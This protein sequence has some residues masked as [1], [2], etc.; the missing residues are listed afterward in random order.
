MRRLILA[1]VCSACLALAL[2]VLAAQPAAPAVAQRSSAFVATDV[3]RASGRVRIDLASLP[4]QFL[5][6]AT[7]E[8]A[9]GS[10]D[11]GLDRA[12][13]VDPVL[14]EFR[15]AGKRALLVQKNMR[16]VARSNDPDESAATRDAFA[17]SVLWAGDVATDASGRA[18]ID[19]DGLLTSDL[20][21][22]VERLDGTKQGKYAL[23]AERS[24]VLADDTR[25]FPDN[26]EFAAL[27]TFAGDGQG[28]FARQA[29]ADAKRIT[30]K[31]RV[32]FVRLPDA[33]YRPRAYHPGSG[34]YSLAFFDFAR[35]IDRNLE[36]R[37]Q[38]RF[39]LEKI[40]P[41]AA[42]S[43]V[44]K[45]IV[46]YL[47]R[48][49]PEPI[50][51]A[52]LEG[53]NWWKAAFESAGFIDAFRAEIAPEGMSMSDVR[54]NT[55]T[56][57]HR[58]TR[59]WSYGGGLVDPRTGE[60]IKGYVNLG[61]QRV[62]QDLLIAEGLLAPH[63]PGADPA[64]MEEAKRMALDRLKQLSAHEVGHA[65]GF[66][67]NFAASRTS[68]GSVLDYPHPMITLGADGQPR[69]ASAYRTGA[70]EWDRFLVAHG[71]GVFPEADE[72]DALARLRAGIAAKGYAY[73]SDPDA[74]VGGDLH[75]EGVLW[76][77]PGDPLDALDH[78]LRTRKAA[79][80]RFAEGA[81]PPD[82]QNGDAER[83]LVPIY[84]LHRYQTDAAM[85]LL[86]GGD[87]RY[88]LIGDGAGGVR[89]VDGARQSRALD[90]ASRLLSLDVLSLPPSV[91]AV[92]S[93]PSNEYVRG[94]EYIGT[95][96]APAFDPVQAAA[97]ASALVAE[98][99]F[100]PA[101]LNRLAW[102]HGQDGGV[103]S[104]AD[105]F[106]ALVARPWREA[107]AA[108]QGALLQS[109]R[110]WT[111]L[112]AALLALDGGELHAGVA[113]QWRASLRA[114]ADAHAGAKDADRQAAAAQVRRY[115]DNPASVK[116]RPLPTIPPGAP[117]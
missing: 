76:D 77:I 73:V 67:H 20:I 48:G 91:L 47:D 75:A 107:P 15:R 17:E 38:P 80:S 83:R 30:V 98:Q 33:G 1:F 95:R 39:R 5:M 96:M 6:F 36:V 100:H 16:Y 40:D 51:S 68:E 115:L 87:Y 101:R 103:P 29:A 43:R 65:L 71:Y 93:P 59:G 49:T 69:L 78:L 10:N 34:A 70:S 86:G 46:F 89:A 94:P 97:V 116:L 72:A 23:A 82:R 8:R 102:Q 31:Q 60:I 84:L 50:R 79:L 3:D 55:I 104:P 81:L 64:L 35:P 37:L 22:V 113:A 52:L 24:A 92:L 2:P 44:K 112:D 88:G 57:T 27:L 117:I 45:P 109:S 54:Y 9:I 111:M 26:A 110:N 13:N 32:S 90:A 74:R 12:Q 28:A 114:F 63:R 19:L 58:A 53:A 106:D 56:W 105:V 41:A 18:W 66:A 21:G 85:R 108:G 4:G 14:V 25:V 61:S 7:L 62:R 11:I 99:G 42:R